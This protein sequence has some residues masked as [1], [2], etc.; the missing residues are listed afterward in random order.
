MNILVTGAE[1]FIGRNLALAVSRLPDHHVLACGRTT[2]AAERNRLLGQA[3]VVIHLAGVNRPDDPAEFR[4][5]NADMTAEICDVLVEQGRRVPV[6]LASS[7]QASLDNAYGESKRLAEDVVRRYAERSGA[8]VAISRLPG[9]FGKWCRPNY[10]SVVATFCHNTARGLPLTVSDPLRQLDLV[11]VDDVVRVLLV[12]VASLPTRAA[13]TVEEPVVA[14]VFTV[15]LGRLVQLVQEFRA[16]R[17]TLE[18]TDM[19]DLFS[20]RLYTTYLS[21]LPTDQFAYDL[22]QHSDPRGVLAEMIKGQ[23]FGQMFVSRT[24]PG[25][26][27]GNHYHDAKVEKFV[28]VEGEAV[29]RFRH[30]LTSEMVEYPVTGRAFRVVDIPPGW[31]HS[32][33]NVGP[34]ELVV[35]FWANERFNPA[36]PD[37]YAAQVLP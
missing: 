20:Q 29:I 8:P 4:K 34:S 35:L 37:T 18:L 12:A 26:T 36:V 16:S 27:R 21:Y 2:A 11:Y 33:E 9:V 10:N 19:T 25:I 28:V 13:A 32:I 15:T 22:T 7:T 17:Q 30:I 1:G 6:V 31:A 23:A 5:V 24:K 3:D 14:P